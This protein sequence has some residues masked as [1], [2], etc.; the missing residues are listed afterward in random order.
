MYAMKK[1]NTMS[2][3]SKQEYSEVMYERHHQVSTTEKSH[4]LDKIR[5]LCYWHREHVIRKLNKPLSTARKRRR[6]PR[7]LS[8]IDA[9]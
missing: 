1:G 6:P 4:L 7:G 2:C 8:W 9:R 3:K 5:R